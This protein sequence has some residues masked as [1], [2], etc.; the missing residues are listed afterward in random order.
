MKDKI[1]HY[2]LSGMISG[3]INRFFL[4]LLYAF[5]LNFTIPY[6]NVLAWCFAQAAKVISLYFKLE[7][8]GAY[9]QWKYK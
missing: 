3:T 7:G 4:L 5:W 8:L 2:N 6:Q 9:P 1:V